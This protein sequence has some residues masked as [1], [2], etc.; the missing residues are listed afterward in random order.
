VKSIENDFR[1]SFEEVINGVRGRN[2]ITGKGR[3]TGEIPE[4]KEGIPENFVEGSG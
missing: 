4:S 2:T 3:V 1:K